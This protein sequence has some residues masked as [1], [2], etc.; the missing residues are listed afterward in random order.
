LNSTPRVGLQA[1]PLEFPRLSLAALALIAPIGAPHAAGGA[2]P[3]EDIEIA[4]TPRL[5]C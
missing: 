4:G 2:V 1:G 3:V 5:C